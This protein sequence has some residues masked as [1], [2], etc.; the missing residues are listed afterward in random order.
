[1][2]RRLTIG[3]YTEMLLRLDRLRDEVVLPPPDL[4]QRPRRRIIAVTRRLHLV[5]FVEDHMD[6]AHR[7]TN[8]ISWTRMADLWNRAHPGQF[9]H[10]VPLAKL[11]GIA[12]RDPLVQRAYRDRRAQRYAET[13][14]ELVSE[15]RKRLAFVVG[16]A[17]DLAT[18]LRPVEIGEDEDPVRLKCRVD[19]AY[20][21][22]RTYQEKQLPYL[23]YDLW[24]KRRNEGAPRTT[25]EK[26]EDK[27]APHD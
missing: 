19:E 17:P 5:E 27:L 3:K 13:F 21:A 20:E 26:K 2:R 16:L 15:D 18:V 7:G 4:N 1:M 9:Y 12:V 25:G 6:R 8:Q 23:E 14:N 11:Y 22:L 24:R 10:P